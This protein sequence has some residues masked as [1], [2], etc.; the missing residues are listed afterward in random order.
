MEYTDFLTE[1]EK[2]LEEEQKI[3]FPIIL[4]SASPRRRELISKIAENYRVEV[5]SAEEI[6]PEGIDALKAPEYLAELKADAVAKDYN[7]QIVIGC[8]TVVIL[9]GKIL[10]KPKDREDAFCMLKSLSGK[11]HF[12][13]SGVCITD[14]ATK[15]V[16]STKS[17]VTFKTLSDREI[18][19]YIDTD[20]CWDKAGA[21]AIQGGAGK[22]VE[23]V[24]G[25]V[26]NIIGFPISQIKK[27]LL[28]K[29]GQ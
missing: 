28:L 22:F 14:S 19:D 23:S 2:R 13:V 12:V 9:E 6:L 24:S 17:E 20:E 1:Y 3:H 5:S 10:G 21:Y 25:S 8:D 16:F 15:A 26:Y 4:A 29:F 18:N 27:E 7:G 11:T